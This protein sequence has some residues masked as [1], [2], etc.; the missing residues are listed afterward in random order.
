MAGLP[1]SSALILGV[2]D[3]VG[4]YLARLLDARGVRVSGVASGRDGLPDAIG[5]LGIGDAVTML[6]A[7]AAIAAAGAGTPD[8]IFA[9]AGAGDGNAAIIDAAAAGVRLAHVVD[10]D[11][12]R[13][14]STAMAGARRIADLRQTQQ[15]LA[16]N[17]I[18]H[19]HDSRFGPRD[20]L[21]ARITG[22]ALRASNDAATP[23]ELIET[24]PRDWGWTPEYV[25]AVLRLA[26]LPVLRDAAVASGHALTT[27]EFADH[28]FAHFG[29]AAADHVTI[30][31][32]AAV[33]DT[34]TTTAAA[35]LKAA[36][37]WSAST[38]GRDLVRALSEGAASR[39]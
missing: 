22:A 37:G 20:S 30:L 36:T 38:H 12:L 8:V 23:L 31:P 6:D 9:I 29:K 7:D 18:L 13:H 15:R 1:Y 4:A 34:T 35:A 16:F 21:P 28:A 19:P 39:A 5:G 2:D 26:A 14:D 24:G 17:A 32:G 25:D 10:I 11:R 33:P 27:A 3:H